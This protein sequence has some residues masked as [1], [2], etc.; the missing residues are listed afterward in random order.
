MIARLT[1]FP[2]VGVDA[3]LLLQLA[4]NLE[5]SAASMGV[6]ASFAADLAQLSTCV[7]RNMGEAEEDCGLWHRGDKQQDAHIVSCSCR[8]SHIDETRYL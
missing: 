2:R 8:R 7:D 6:M 5:E 1:F 4:L 3:L